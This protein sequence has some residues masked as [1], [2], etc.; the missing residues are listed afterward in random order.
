MNTEPPVV[1]HFL[2][3]GRVEYDPHAPLAPYS[4]RNVVFRHRPPAEAAYPIVAPELWVFVHLDGAGNHEVWI[5][6]VRAPDTDT[7]T[8]SELVA[9]YGP[10]VVRFGPQRVGLSRG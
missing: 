6:V 3:C 8:E 4:V 10:F 7:D 2:V 5:E 9:A 1:R